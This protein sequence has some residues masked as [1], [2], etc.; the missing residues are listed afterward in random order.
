[1]PASPSLEHKKPILRIRQSNTASEV[2]ALVEERMKM[3]KS[4]VLL[5]IIHADYLSVKVFVHH[6]SELP[7]R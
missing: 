6:N 5:T 1:V 2:S 7:T 3:S 4:K